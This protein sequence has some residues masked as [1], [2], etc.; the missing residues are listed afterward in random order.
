[1]VAG[2]RLQPTNLN[3]QFSAIGQKK[4]VAAPRLGIVRPMNELV[5]R[6][7]SRIPLVLLLEAA[8]HCKRASRTL[9]QTA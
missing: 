3:S 6:T 7:V 2:R 5:H 9:V 8:A 4:N 1:M